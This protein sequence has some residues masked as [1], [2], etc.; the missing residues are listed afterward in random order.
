MRKA[1]ARIF[2]GKAFPLTLGVIANAVVFVER[3]WSILQGS[4]AFAGSDWVYDDMCA[5]FVVTELLLLLLAGVT[6]RLS[7]KVGWKCLRLGRAP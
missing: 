1:L 5:A 3:A 7:W 4:I 2:W 6:L